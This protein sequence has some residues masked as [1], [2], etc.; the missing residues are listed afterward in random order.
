MQS[1]VL[2]ASVLLPEILADRLILITHTHPRV[3]KFRVAPSCSRFP[4]VPQREENR[5]ASHRALLGDLHGATG[6]SELERI[7]KDHRVQ[8]LDERAAADPAH[9]FSVIGTMLSP[10]EPMLPALPQ[11]PHIFQNSSSLLK[12]NCKDLGGKKKKKKKS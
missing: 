5:L 9:N 11:F 10:T 8:R 3:V 6:Y 12:A 2:P 4:K 1:W 7:H